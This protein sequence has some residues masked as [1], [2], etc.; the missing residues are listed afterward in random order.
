MLETRLSK[1]LISL[2]LCAAVFGSLTAA[3]VGAVLRPSSRGQGVENRFAVAGVDDPRQVEEF[4]SE[5]KDAVERDERARVASLVSFPMRLNSARRKAL[6]RSRR[7][8]LRRYESI[9]TH[10]IKQVLKGQRESELFVNSE[11]VMVGAGEI[12]FAPVGR[13]G[14]LKIVTVN[15]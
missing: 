3:G 11:G 13:D 4:L 5:L 15:N 7:D 1:T 2:A 12:W 10:E 14:R 9:F 6:V 8:F